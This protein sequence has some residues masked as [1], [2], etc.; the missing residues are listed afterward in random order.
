MNAR[1]IRT[2]AAVGEEPGC[3]GGSH[4]LPRQQLPAFKRRPSE[5]GCYPHGPAV[6]VEPL[7]DSLPVQEEAAA[8]RKQGGA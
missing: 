5:A 8:T 4:V 1:A 3:A 7:Q 2:E 6:R